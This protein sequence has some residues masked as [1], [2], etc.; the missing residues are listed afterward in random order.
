MSS[1]WSQERYIAAFRFAAERHKGQIFTGS[2]LPYLM[3]LSFVSMEVIA[4]LNVEDGLDGDLAVQCACLH[5]VI[6]DTV[7]TID[8]LAECFGAAVATGVL[9]L[10]KDETLSKAEQISDSLRRIREQP[11]EVAIVKLADRITNLQPP[12]SHWTQEKIRSYAMEA[13]VIYDALAD[14]SP[15]LA[16]RFREKLASYRATIEA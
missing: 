2:D 16:T 13:R 1:A 10:T 9:A 5:D 3:H 14:A 15:F 6:E 12:P 4:A 11:R 8:E 7:T